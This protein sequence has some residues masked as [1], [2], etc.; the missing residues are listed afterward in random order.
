MNPLGSKQNFN[1]APVNVVINNLAETI[2]FA[3]SFRSPED[4]MFELHRQNP[5]EAHRIMQLSKTLK[6]P[7]QAAIQVLSEHGIAPEQ[8]QAL[9]GQKR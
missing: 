4:F 6:N 7:M 2:N 5:Q 9:L 3:K 1:K 8:I